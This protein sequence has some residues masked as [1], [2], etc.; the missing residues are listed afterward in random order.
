MLRYVFNDNDTVAGLVQFLVP[1]CRERGFGRCQCMGVVDEGHRLIA[2]VVYHNYDPGA[3]V[4]EI[5]G[6]A[7]TPRWLTR[8]TLMLMHAYPFMEVGAQMVVMRVPAENT[9]L[10]R[11]LASYGYVFI[12]VPRMLGRGRDGVLATLTYEDWIENRFNRS[13]RDALQQQLQQNAAEPAEQRA[14]QRDHPGADAG[15]EPA[16]VYPDAAGADDADAS[17][18]DGWD[19]VRSDDAVAAARAAGRADDTRDARRAAKPA[20][21]PKRAKRR[22][23]AAARR[24]KPDRTSDAAAP[25][26]TG[27]RSV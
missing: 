22:K 18:L 21:K 20:R 10:L 7:L 4:I 17:W 16:A 1:S 13:L 5:S 12:R 9:R 2:G 26:L 8:K 6:A 24:R 15:A 14:A 19:G 25:V 27:E 3:G 23:P 11:Q